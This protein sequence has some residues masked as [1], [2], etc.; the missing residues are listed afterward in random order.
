MN[1]CRLAL[2]RLRQAPGFTAVAVLT[3]A[4]AIGANTAVF[5]I[6]DAVLFRP[7]PYESPDRLVTV[8]MRDA[9]TGVRYTSVSVEHM[10]FLSG[11]NDVIEGIG[12]IDLDSSLPVRTDSGTESVRRAIATADY[13]TVLGS[14][15]A[16]GRLFDESDLAAGGE[17]VLLTWA[18]FQRRFGGDDAIVGATVRLGNQSL[19]VVGVLPSDFI[20]PSNFVRGAEIVGLMRQDPGQDD[21]I[22]PIARLRVG[23]DPATAQRR[24]NALAKDPTFPDG[25]PQLEDIRTVLYPTGRGIMKFLLAASV[26]VLL[27]GCANL[28]NMLLVR[29]RLG[30]RQIGVQAAL[31]ASP[32]Q[33]L[34]PLVIEALALGVAGSIA[35]LIMTMLTSE[36]LVRQ[37]PSAVI[38]QAPVGVDS[39]VASF[40]LA[41]GL[42]A[43]LAFSIIPSWRTSRLDATLVLRIAAVGPES[44]S[45]L[46]RPM[47]V[48]QVALAVVLVFGALLAARGLISV[49]RVPLGFDPE[50]VIAL[51]Y[52]PDAQDGAGRQ[53]GY[54]GALEEIRA[55]PDVIAAGATGGLPITGFGPN[56]GAVSPEFG[57][58]T[59]AVFHV[60]PGYFEAV[61]IQLLRG[62][63]PSQPDIDV[64]ADVAVVAESAGRLLFPGQDPLGQTFIS[65]TGRAIRVIGVVAEVTD[66]LSRKG[67]PPVYAI[68]NQATRAL[69]LVIR[70]RV[71]SDVALAEIR[72]RV[73]DRAPDVPIS[74][75]WWSDQISEVGAYRNPRFQTIV[76]GSFATLALVLTGLGVFGLVGFLVAARMQELGIRIAIGAAPGRVLRHALSHALIP[77]VAGI[78]VGVLATR[79]LADLAASQL[80]EVETSDPITLLA[81]GLAVAVAAAMAAWL[82]ARRAARIDPM[83]VLRMN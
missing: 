69:T 6:A 7:L 39:R 83:S 27:L 13:F 15:P 48:T 72:R 49:I 31:G 42:I 78:G 10:K 67:R 54:V 47:L 8:L 26:L 3:L 9:E 81:A 40:A 52:L 64:G 56:E 73:S 45:S 1:D 24:I 71:R 17:P 53:A 36:V 41:L 74:A 19:D 34:R 51:R 58:I 12:R 32:S 62:R 35:A 21:A 18:T 20:F 50:Q 16:R 60:L 65:S 38:G 44:R 79:L 23:V 28:T 80:Y 43:A 29:S 57:D 61:G 2:R 5:S 76:L 46:G 77:T 22:H 30:K 82:P 68:P 4:L 37:I 11:L 59:V 33:L 14:H 75:E 70:T 55:L 63:L 66:S 25:T